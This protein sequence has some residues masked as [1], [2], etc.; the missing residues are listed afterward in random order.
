MTLVR[1]ELERSADALQARLLLDAR[2]QPLL[3]ELAR[4]GDASA[5]DLAR[6]LDRPLSSV[7]AQLERLLAA[8][9]VDLSGLRARAGRPVRLYHLPLPW[10]VPFEVTPAATLRELIGSS[11]E[12]RLREQLDHLAVAMARAE[13]QWEVRV[14]WMNDQLE[15]S[16]RP[17]RRSDEPRL[18]GVVGTGADLRLTP[19]RALAFKERLN[20]LLEEFQ[21][22]Q[23][24]AGER[25]AITVLLTPQDRRA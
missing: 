2:L 25:W 6:T 17:L 3:T 10:R 4:L 13:G 14:D 22:V 19:G 11:F 20:Q 21:A 15:N 23:D 5:G 16:I 24:D 7:H 8:G 9:V 18:G 1:P 12:L